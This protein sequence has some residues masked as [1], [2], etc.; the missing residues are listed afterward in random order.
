MIK[1]FRSKALERFWGKV[2]FAAL[3]PGMWQN[4]RAFSMCWRARQILERWTRTIHGFTP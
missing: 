1:S 3:I 2:R 4:S